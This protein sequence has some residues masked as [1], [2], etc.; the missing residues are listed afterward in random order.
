[1][2]R[3]R[4]L[5][6]SDNTFLR[7]SLSDAR[8]ELEN[9]LR[10]RG[11]MQS[12]LDKY[13]DA[14]QLRQELREG[15]EAKAELGV[16]TEKM[17]GLLAREAMLEEHV[18][19]AREE[20]KKHQLE[21]QIVALVGL[22][23]QGCLS[24]DAID[25]AGL[26][27]ADVWANGKLKGLKLYNTFQ[28]GK[29]EIQKSTA[30]QQLREKVREL[31][32]AHAT[33]EEIGAINRAQE[34][35]LKAVTGALSRTQEWAEGALVALQASFE[36]KTTKLEAM[37]R[38]LQDDRVS[39]TEKL[40]EQLDKL[41]CGGGEHQR[42]TS[43]LNGEILVESH[44]IYPTVEGLDVAITVHFEMAERLATTWNLK[45][46][47]LEFRTK[48]TEKISAERAALHAANDQV[49]RLRSEVAT[50]E[51]AVERL[52]SS[53]RPPLMRGRGARL[54]ATLEL[55]VER[56]G[57]DSQSLRLQLYGKEEELTKSHSTCQGLQAALAQAE[58]RRE[59][60]RAVT[61]ALDA[62]GGTRAPG[63]L[64]GHQGPWSFGWAL[65]GR[66][67]LTALHDTVVQ[68]YQQR[69]GTAIVSSAVAKMHIAVQ[70]RQ[71]E[72]LS[73]KCRAEI[74]AAQ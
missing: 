51:L 37:M 62:L 27:L 6:V 30:D 26:W 20:L 64:G 29:I 44:E 41:M 28:L 38:R 31:G 40:A 47:A 45:L 23:L 46:Q 13:L 63:R 11:A 59:A 68:E 35:K 7:N 4:A 70:R 10:E 25:W 60:S 15:E 5:I 74:A 17:T 21:G 61:K 24:A 9:A 14:S 53:K 72:R 56:L 69:W 73:S 43:L 42:R 3:A 65:E 18:V 22:T 66:R 34:N 54:V 58:E 19:Q 8:L 71:M 48:D 33:I 2:H 52:A 49:T 36:R 16:L 12:Y 55:A 50:L 39:E 67:V 57:R 1:M 32:E